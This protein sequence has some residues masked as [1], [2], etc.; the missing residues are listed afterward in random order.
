MRT[1]RQLAALNDVNGLAL[2]KLE[3]AA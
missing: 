2:R 3:L 1:D